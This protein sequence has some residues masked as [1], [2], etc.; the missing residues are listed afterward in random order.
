[1]SKYN[2]LKLFS[3]P[4]KKTR[5]HCVACAASKAPHLNLMKIFVDIFPPEK[6]KSDPPGTTEGRSIKPEG[7][8]ISAAVTKMVE[9]QNFW[10]KF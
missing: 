9:P 6:K 5:S 7:W 2:K 8:R 3:N 10:G 1:M 4:L